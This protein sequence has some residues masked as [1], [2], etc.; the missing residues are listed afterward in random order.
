MKN[1]VKYST[2]HNLKDN[3]YHLICQP[4]EDYGHYLFTLK[5]NK[6]SYFTETK[7]GILLLITIRSL[8]SD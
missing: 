7:V 4:Y 6:S 5:V 8:F 2:I 3:H 1:Q